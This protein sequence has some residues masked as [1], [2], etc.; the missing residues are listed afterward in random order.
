MI[1][2]QILTKSLVGSF[3]NLLTTI[4][5]VWRHVVTT[6]NLAGGCIGR[7]S[8]SAQRVV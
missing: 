8:G 2:K 4:E 3:Y 5:T 6:M 7:Q 1:Q